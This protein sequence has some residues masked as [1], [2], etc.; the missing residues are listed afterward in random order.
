MVR[1]SHMAE[2][3]Y[4]QAA[5]DD[6]QTLA[7]LRCRFIEE[8]T[9]K[10]LDPQLRSN[11]RDAYRTMISD[12]RAVACL[13]FDSAD[14]TQA[15][16]TGT[17]IFWQRIPGPHSATGR[18]AYI[19]NMYTLPEFRRRG[20]A[21]TILAHLVETAKQAGLTRIALHSLPEAT[22]VYVKAGFVR[23]DNEMALR[24]Q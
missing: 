12:G 5:T 9:G 4:R 15:A 24:W 2:I 11:I 20:I 8:A 22:S 14:Q 1:L 23:T 3:C 16:G 7:D 6:F 21:T 10:P 13:A 19:M 18:Y 17:L